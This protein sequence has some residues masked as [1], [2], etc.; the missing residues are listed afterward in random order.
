MRTFSNDDDEEVDDDARDSAHKSPRYG[1]QLVLNCRVACCVVVVVASASAQSPNDD[2]DD[3]DDDE[4]D[5]MGGDGR[6]GGDH[7]VRQRS[8]TDG[9]DTMETTR[10]VA[11]VEVEA[12]AMA[13][14]ARS[15]E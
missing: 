7:G 13:R 11:A 10:R 8:N 6:G 5:A 15:L 1:A 3:D 4:V 2:D 9:R 12:S 14:T